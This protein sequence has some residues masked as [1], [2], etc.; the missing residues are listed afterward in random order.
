LSAEDRE[1]EVARRFVLFASTT[2]K[3]ALSASPTGNPQTMA[4]RAAAMAWRILAP[5][6]IRQGAAALSNT[7]NEKRGAEIG[8]ELG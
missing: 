7:V 8:G 3:N 2:S 1:F 5:G 4:K 6:L